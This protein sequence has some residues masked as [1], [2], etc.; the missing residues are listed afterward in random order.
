[1]GAGHTLSGRDRDGGGGGGV[2]SSKR[3]T[4]AGLSSGN[5]LGRKEKAPRWREQPCEG[6]RSDRYKCVVHWA[7]RREGDHKC[8]NAERGRGGGLGKAESLSL[9]PGI[10][11]CLVLLGLIII[12]PFFK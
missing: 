7:G 10:R 6:I 12:K 1:V 9:L 3:N 2:L 8:T 5:I 11:V 4:W